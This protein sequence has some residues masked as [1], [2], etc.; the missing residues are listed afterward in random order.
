MTERDRETEIVSEDKERESK[1]ETDK[2]MGEIVFMFGNKGEYNEQ[3]NEPGTS[4]RNMQTRDER[5]GFHS[6]PLGVS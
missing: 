4:Q 2:D 6:K 1:R 5:S 3:D